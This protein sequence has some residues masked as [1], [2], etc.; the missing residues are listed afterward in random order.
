MC[1]HFLSKVW[2]R[3]WTRSRRRRSCSNWLHSHYSGG[4]WK[5]LSKKGCSLDMKKLSIKVSVEDGAA[6]AVVKA[7]KE[8]RTAEK[9]RRWTTSPP[10]HQDLCVEI[11]IARP[12]SAR[13]QSPAFRNNTNNI[14]YAYTSTI[15]LAPDGNGIYLIKFH[16]NAERD[17]IIVKPP[18]SG[19][20]QPAAFRDSSQKEK[21]NGSDEYKF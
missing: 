10:R 17:A 19:T 18:H 8:V 15:K 9:Q 1:V 2:G 5:G 12:L 13:I 4:K 16:I 6:G 21:K 3:K 14:P 11:Y 7:E 20:L